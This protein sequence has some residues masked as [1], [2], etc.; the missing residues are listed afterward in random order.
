MIKHVFSDMDYTF[1]GKD[2]IITKENIETIKRLKE[3]GIGFSIQS[4]RLPCALEDILDTTGTNNK[5]DEYMI[6][7]NGAIISNTKKEFLY[8][9]HIEKETVLKLVDY[10]YALDNASFFMMVSKDYYYCSEEPTMIKKRSDHKVVDKETMYKLANNENIYKFLL[11]NESTEELINSVKE[12]KVLTN[13]EIDGVLSSPNWMEI[14]KA[15]TNKGEGIRKF[16]E[17]KGIDIKDVLAIGDNFNDETMLRVAG[18]SGCPSNA[19]Q[20]MKDLCEYVSPVDCDNSA[21]AD[22][23]KHFVNLEE[24]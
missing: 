23:V 12:I 9:S 17:I 7:G 20:E 8:E 6:C 22:I 3:M 2:R 24:E 21:F 11:L 5:S 13:N 1:F 16:C 4:G 18:H 14:I 15:S 19:V 10:C